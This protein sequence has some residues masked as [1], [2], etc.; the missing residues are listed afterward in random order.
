MIVEALYTYSSG[1]TKE[2]VRKCMQK[3]SSVAVFLFCCIYILILKCSLVC[4]FEMR[5]T[6]FDLRCCY[7]PQLLFPYFENRKPCRT[8]CCTLHLTR[9][10]RSSET[11]D[12]DAFRSNECEYLVTQVR[13]ASGPIYALLSVQVKV[14]VKFTL[15]RATTAQRESRG[16]VLL[17]L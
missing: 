2:Q 8:M 17:F 4:F 6:V 5:A 9:V 16:I 11:F 7:I 10:L 1:K 13:E 3:M 15:E 12:L 14:K